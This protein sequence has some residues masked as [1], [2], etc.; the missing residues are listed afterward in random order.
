MTVD[1]SFIASGGA[2]DDGDEMDMLNQTVYHPSAAA[3][4][5]NA[6]ASDGTST[7]AATTGPRAAPAANPQMTLAECQHDMA[8][9]QTELLQWVFINAMLTK[10]YEAQEQHAAVRF[11]RSLL[12]SQKY[13]LMNSR[14]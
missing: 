5:N 14:Y 7:A 4:T 2:E 13:P 8:V 6:S 12:L 3:T 10:S 9:L 1:D 11:P